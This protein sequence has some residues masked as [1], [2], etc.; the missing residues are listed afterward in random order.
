MPPIAAMP[1]S[2]ISAVSAMVTGNSAGRGT[3]PST[4]AAMT[5]WQ[6]QSTGPRP[7]RRE[8]TG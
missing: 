1:A 3:N 6:T 7:Y 5:A 8:R 2:A 4:P